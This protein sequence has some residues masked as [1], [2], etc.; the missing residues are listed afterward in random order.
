MFSHGLTLLIGTLMAVACISRSIMTRIGRMEVTLDHWVR[1]GWAAGYL[2]PRPGC[3][4]SA[5]APPKP[6][7]CAPCTTCPAASTTARS[8]PGLV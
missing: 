8:L 5:P 7:G 2:H 6:S 3:S 1:R 4:S